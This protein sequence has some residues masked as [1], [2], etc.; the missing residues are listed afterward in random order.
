MRGEGG[1]LPRGCFGCLADEEDRG[2]QGA[3][4]D[5]R[6]SGGGEAGDRGKSSTTT[7]AALAAAVLFL[8]ITIETFGAA[9]RLKH[10]HSSGRVVGPRK[11][12]ELPQNYPFLPRP[13]TRLFR[14]QFTRL[15]DQSTTDVS[16]SRL[17]HATCIS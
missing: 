8:E 16:P 15:L 2:R 5:E 1:R 13:D 11:N 10:D 9:C 12:P 3:A 4:A 17:S 7:V 6:S 14:R